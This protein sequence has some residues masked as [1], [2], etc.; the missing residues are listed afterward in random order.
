MPVLLTT[1]EKC[2]VW[3]RAPWSEAATLQRPLPDDEMVVVARGA[4][5]E[6]GEV[7]NDVAEPQRSPSLPVITAD[8]ISG[9]RRGRGHGGGDRDLRHDHYPPNRWRPGHPN[10]RWRLN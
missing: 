1:A 2:D 9:A 6:D 8:A 10:G 3:M 5:K 7:L 4:S